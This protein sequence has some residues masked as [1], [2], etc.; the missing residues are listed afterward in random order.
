VPVA[1]VRELLQ[2]AQA[3]A[4]AGRRW[5]REA[6]WYRQ[7]GGRV[8]DRREALAAVVRGTVRASSLVENC[9]SRLGNYLFWRRQ[10]GPDYLQ[11]LRIY[12]NHR[13]YPLRSRPERTGHSPRATDR[14]VARPVAR[15]VGAGR[16]TAQR[17]ALKPALPFASGKSRGRSVV[18]PKNARF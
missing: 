17:N 12:L 4:C 10:V 6:V 8:H 1:Q 9:N 5:A 7:L 14:P 18:L 2:V 16:T 15:A 13:P 3:S 11:L